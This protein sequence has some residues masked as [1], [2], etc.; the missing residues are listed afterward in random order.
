MIFD[1]VLLSSIKEG[2]SSQSFNRQDSIHFRSFSYY[3]GNRH[4]VCPMIEKLKEMESDSNQLE[5]DP[6]PFYCG[7]HR[8]P[9]R[10]QLFFLWF[11]GQAW[12]E[13]LL[14]E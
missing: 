8:Q 3:N 2:K 14:A 5:E 12:P 6:A 11:G 1:R 7:F 4:H 9:N 13:R 10:R